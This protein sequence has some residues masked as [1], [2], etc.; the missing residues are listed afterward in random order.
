MAGD[1]A[2]DAAT[3][4][5]FPSEPQRKGDDGTLASDMETAVMGAMG[6]VSLRLGE[7]GR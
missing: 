3:N 1:A 5:L 2:R 4:C 6:L 7:G